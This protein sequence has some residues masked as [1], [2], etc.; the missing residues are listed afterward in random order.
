DPRQVV[1]A[2]LVLRRRLL[3]PPCLQQ[4]DDVRVDLPPPAARRLVRL[5]VVLEP[6]VRG[7]VRHRQVAGEDVVEGRD[8]GRALDRRVAA[9]RGCVSEGSSD[10]GSPRCS[11]PCAPCAAW[12]F[13]GT[14]PFSRAPAALCMSTPSYC[15]L[16]MSY[17]CCSGSQPEKSPSSSSTS[18]NSSLM[19][20]GAIV[21]LT[22]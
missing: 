1:E 20:T 15:Q 12:P 4:A 22:T 19:I 9:Q 8:V 13:V 3:A 21:Y 2:E 7:D 6:L 16:S 11:F 14:K 10:G 18:L 17:F 5:D